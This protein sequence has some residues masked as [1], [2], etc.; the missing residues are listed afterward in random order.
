MGK[1]AQVYLGS[2]ELAAIISKLGRIP[3]KDEYFRLV[4]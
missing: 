4:R 3:T 1:N 2:S